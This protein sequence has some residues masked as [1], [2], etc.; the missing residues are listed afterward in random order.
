MARISQKQ[1]CGL[2]SPRSL[3]LTVLISAAIGVSVA[4]P[5]FAAPVA[6]DSGRVLKETIPAPQ[7]E[8]KPA[9]AMVVQPGQAKPALQAQPGLKVKVTAFRITGNTVFPEDELLAL[10]SGQVG[11]ELDF[12]GLNRA[13]NKIADYY[14]SK[15]YFLAQAYL[16]A[17]AIRDGSVEIA[18]LEGR[19]GEVKLRMGKNARLRE[20]RA[21]SIL[22]AAIHPGDLINDKSLER[23]LLLLNDT[24][25]AVVTSTLQPGAKVGTADTVVDLGDDGHPVAGSVVLDNWGNRYTGENRLS[26]N[27]RIKNPTGYG[28][29]LTATGLVSNGDGGSPM[30]RLSYVAPVGPLGTKLGVSYNKVEYSLGKDFA[31]LQAHGFAEVYS[32]YALHPFVRSRNFNVVGIA[33]FDRKKFEDRIDTTATVDNKTADAYNLGVSGDFSDSVFG[34]SINAFSVTATNGNVDIK[35]PALKLLDQSAL[36]YQTLGSYTKVDYK[37]ERQQVL[38]DN[39]SLLVAVNGQL[40]SKN[41]ISGEQ[42]SLGGPQGVRAYPVGEGVGDE[43]VVLNTELRWNVPRSDFMLNT[44]VDYG[45]SRLH[46]TQTLAD[47]AAGTANTRNILGYGLGLD[48]GK[49]ND[50]LLRTSIAWRSDRVDNAPQADSTNHNPRAWI[51]LTKWY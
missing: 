37:Y 20:S 27:L 50:Y 43:G 6:P 45:H 19:V 1:P 4:N 18:V 24:P 17:Q 47:I 34:G 21:R 42:F 5:V 46:K 12:E 29:L 40:A 44:F 36:G 23:G 31:S 15:G 9:P 51:Q 48:Y 26:A 32:V 35:D 22:D 30:G 11:K 39:V 10:I 7:T 38:R 16:P 14:R 13:A 28:D 8:L 41:L 49:K 25:G 2:Q 33:G 3:T